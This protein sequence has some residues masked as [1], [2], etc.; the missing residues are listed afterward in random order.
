MTVN[1]SLCY[2]VMGSLAHFK[3]NPSPLH[4]VHQPSRSC[5]QQQTATLQVSNLCSNVCTAV[6]H[7][8]THTGPV[9]KL[10]RL[11]VDLGGELSGGSEDKAQG[12]L[13]A[14]TTSVPWL[15]KDSKKYGA[16]IA[17]HFTY[18]EGRGGREREGRGGRERERRERRE[19]ERRE[20]ERRERERRERERMGG[21]RVDKK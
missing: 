7:T 20:R 10:A 9:G 18:V 11:V 6:H 12:V 8:G 16:S 14:A 2:C 15:E 17:T 4:H 1:I 13:L 21:K 19:R 5:H 3:S